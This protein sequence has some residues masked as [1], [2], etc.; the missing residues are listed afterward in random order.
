MR[1]QIV[2]DDDVA[3]GEFGR[4][5]LAYISAESIAIHRAIEHKRRHEAADPQPSR[6]GRRLP[7]AVRNRGKTTLSFRSPPAE[8]CHLGGGRGLVDE[9]QP[10]RIKIEL[11]L[12]PLLAS[13]LN[14]AAL[15]LGGMRRLFLNV[16]R[17][18]LKKRHSVPIPALTP[19]A[20]NFS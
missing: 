18:R 15:L 17:R 14:V 2:H 3:G 13:S 12:E 20:F 11:P 16:M 19:R 9:D 6:E 7:M 8:A 1:R 4:K 5:D 10:F